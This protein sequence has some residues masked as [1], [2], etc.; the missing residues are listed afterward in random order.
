MLAHVSRQ[1]NPQLEGFANEIHELAFKNK[2]NIEKLEKRVDA[3][4]AVD[5]YLEGYTSALSD[6]IDKIKERL[7]E[8]ERSLEP[9][10]GGVITSINNRIDNLNAELNHETQLRK[11]LSVTVEAL[12]RDT[13]MED[14]KGSLRY[15]LTALHKSL[16]AL[17]DKVAAIEDRLNN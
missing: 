14:L 16:D 11:D 9:K 8:A 13:I 6:S 15:D 3:Q 12:I 5:D 1:Q 10:G 2:D 7:E 4:E 17:Y